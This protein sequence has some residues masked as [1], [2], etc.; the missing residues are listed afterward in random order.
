MHCIYMVS[1]KVGTHSVYRL[2][3]CICRGL[4]RGRSVDIV[5]I[6]AQW[7]GRGHASAFKSRSL[8]TPFPL[9]PPDGSCSLP[10]RQLLLLPP[11]KTRLDHGFPVRIVV[12]RHLWSA[13]TFPAGVRGRDAKAST[14]THVQV[15]S[16]FYG[17]LIRMHLPVLDNAL[18][19]RID[20]FDLLLRVGVDERPHEGDEALDGPVH[21]LEDGAG[22]G[23]G[24]VR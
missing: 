20:K 9:L 19:G 7:P 11:P 21:I 23:L 5:R 1:D 18:L 12:V 8:H 15:A 13:L 14:A 22:E 2:Q 10:E 3:P 6:P 24:V 16:A 4:A 17:E